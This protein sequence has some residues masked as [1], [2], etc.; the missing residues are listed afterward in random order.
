MKGKVS[1]IV[2]AYNVENYLKKCMTS[3]LNQTY[4]NIEILLI[5]DGSTDNTGTIADEYNLDK[6]KVYH[7]KNGGLSD[8]RN[9]G[10]DRITGDY[11]TF[12]DADDYVYEKYIEYLVDLMQ[13]G[14]NQ[15]AC[16]AAQTFCKDE[17]L[18]L[19]FE[20]S[21][22]FGTAEEAAKK[23]LLRETITHSA[24]GK[25]YVSDVWKT[26]RFPYGKL[27][28]D[29]YTTFDA[30]RKAKNV[31]VSRAKMYFYYQREDS[32]MHY[33]C[34]EKTISIVEASQ[35]VTSRIVAYW[36]ELEEE[37]KGLQIALCLKCLQKIYANDIDSYK[38][39]QKKIRQIINSN[40]WIIFKSK[41]INI[42]DKVKVLML[43]FPPKLYL[44]MY[45]KFDGDIKAV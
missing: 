37:A 12:V 17:D 34:N 19:N 3:L 31:A 9:Y 22:E 39:V 24:W 36:P 40:K 30:V 5:D 32:I 41:R 28:E 43:Y 42:K 10:L 6:V 1:I 15:I 33:K 25:L 29:Y 16:L 13:D 26:L 8:A 2:P 21:A 23:M 44:Y 14:K 20:M 18:D 11:V 4:K 45:N 35:D 38:N 27:Y 7:K